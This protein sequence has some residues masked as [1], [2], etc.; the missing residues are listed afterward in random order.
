MCEGKRMPL[1]VLFSLIHPSGVLLF[2][3]ITTGLISSLLVKVF[4]QIIR[5]PA[6]RPLFPFRFPPK[7]NSCAQVSPFCGFQSWNGDR[8]YCNRDLQCEI[9][10]RGNWKSWGEIF[11]KLSKSSSPST[12]KKYPIKYMNC[13]GS[14]RFFPRILRGYPI[15]GNTSSTLLEL[16]MLTSSLPINGLWRTLQP[17]IIGV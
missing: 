3:R 11:H 7:L 9:W 1:A 12:K 14:L 6:S 16:D 13:K 15:I 2:S 8:E 4:R 5:W 10:R 17:K